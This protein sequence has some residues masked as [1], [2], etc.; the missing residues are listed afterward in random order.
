M[1]L[2][3]RRARE[4][5]AGRAVPHYIARRA[6]HPGA[7][8]SAGSAAFAVRRQAAEVRRP[9]IAHVLTGYQP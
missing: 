7:S 9:M 4:G 8:P 6:R 3:P 2:D 1:V 5:P